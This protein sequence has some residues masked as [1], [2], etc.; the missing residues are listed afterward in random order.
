MPRNDD[1]NTVT[2]RRSSRLKSRQGMPLISSAGSSF[3]LKLELVS[4]CIRPRTYIC[5]SETQTSR[6]DW[7]SIAI[8]HPHCTLH[9]SAI[10]A[11][12]IWRTWP[13]WEISTYQGEGAQSPLWWAR[14]A[15][16]F[17][18]KERGWGF[19]H[20]IA[21]CGAGS[22]INFETTRRIFHVCI[23]S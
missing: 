14:T 21:D 23:V 15:G 20:D 8:G 17:S 1:S 2:T 7:K 13:T 22:W 11:D 18:H 16:N 19:Y 4:G 3:S 12:N 10:T 5:P 6:T 9:L